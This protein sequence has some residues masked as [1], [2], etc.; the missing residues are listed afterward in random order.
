[1]GGQFLILWPK[2]KGCSPSAWGRLCSSHP[3]PLWQVNW[4]H[5]GNLGWWNRRRSWLPADKNDVGSSALFLP[6][7]GAGLAWE[8]GAAGAGGPSASIHA[9]PSPRRSFSGPALPWRGLTFLAG[10][11]SASPSQPEDLSQSSHG[12]KV[13]LF[14]GCLLAL[15][16]AESWAQHSKE[17][18]WVWKPLSLHLHWPMHVHGHM[19]TD[20]HTH[21]YVWLWTTLSSGDLLHTCVHLPFL[22]N[23]FSTITC[24][25][26]LGYFP[27]LFLFLLS[28]SQNPPERWMCPCQNSKL[29]LLN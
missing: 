23:W 1:M 25:G 6:A 16:P 11:P 29:N 9:C 4:G 12:M 27:F 22:L 18:W 28:I 24:N 15:A 8:E 20:M 3:W 17:G 13:N 21:F 7:D 10:C 19:S 14:Q 5:G 2:R 26:Q